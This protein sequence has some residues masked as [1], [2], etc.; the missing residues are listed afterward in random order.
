MYENHA[1]TAVTDIP[2]LVGTFAASLGF[3]TD[4]SV[5]TQPVIRNPQGGDSNS[6]SNSAFNL[7]SDAIP[8]R[9]TASVAG[10]VHTLRVDVAASTNDS[11]SELTREITSGA[12]FT[13]PIV[14]A[15]TP[16][17]CLPVELH[18]IGSLSPKPYI[19]IIV[20]YNDVVGNRVYRHLYIG[21]MEKKGDYEGGE[22]ISA[23]DGI[24]TGSTGTRSY[25]DGSYKYLFGSRNFV[26]A[27]DSG[28]VHVQ[29]AD[30]A[31]PWLR[32]RG[33]FGTQPLL[34]IPEGSALGG[35]NDAINDGYIARARSQFG[36][37]Q[38]LTPINLFHVVVIPGD[39]VPTPIGRPAGVRLVNMQDLQPEA[40]IIVGGMLFKVFPACARRFETVSPKANPSGSQFAEYETTH[41]V[42]YAYALDIEDSNSAGA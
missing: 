2:A 18:L 17:V 12:K 23:S 28:G 9:V 1:I 39:V 26:S 34:A 20:R 24:A 31:I 32:F 6:G 11:N 13:S 41:W 40:E 5:P 38:Q 42:G 30:N 3:E 21:N 19:A 14:G 33:G 4:L 37:Q 15:V 22:V 36:G 25:D 29:H 7:T 10:S 8:W 16:A 27:A 35:Y